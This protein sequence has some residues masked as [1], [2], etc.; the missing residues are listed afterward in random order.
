MKGFTL[1]ELMVVVAIVGI[2]SALAAPSYFSHIRKAHREEAVSG[3][4]TEAQN[5]E[6]YFT[7]N[8][9]YSAA[10]LSTVQAPPSGTAVYTISFAGGQPTTST[11]TILATPVVGGS[12]D[13]DECGTLQLTQ[14]GVQSV[15]GGTLSATECWS[16]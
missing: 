5:L 10:P 11:Y 13:G 3:L 16:H 14:A 4:L 9:S 2:L 8:N 6:N 7:S 1:I 15:S 12:M